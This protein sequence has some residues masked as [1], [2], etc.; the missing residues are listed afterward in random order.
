MLVL[1]R[2][3]VDLYAN[4]GK[5]CQCCEA[6]KCSPGSSLL[7]FHQNAIV[8]SIHEDAIVVVVG[9]ESHGSAIWVFPRIGVPQNGWFIMEN[10]TKMG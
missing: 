3:P 7:I 10:P 9:S 2:V 6:A 5:A 4:M 8:E 1:R